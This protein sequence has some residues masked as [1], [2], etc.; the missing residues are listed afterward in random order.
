MCDA[1]SKETKFKLINNITSYLIYSCAY[2]HFVNGT[3]KSY[4]LAKGLIFSFT[5]Q[6]E[7]YVI[8]KLIKDIIFARNIQV[9]MHFASKV[10]MHRLTSAN[11]MP[12]THSI[13]RSYIVFVTYYISLY[14][15]SKKTCVFYL[16]FRC[17]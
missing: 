7:V 13:T 8:L 9:Q 17:F 15:S 16:S 1:N 12:T 10:T 14:Y 4:C 11:S 5:N 3:L 6:C 2:W